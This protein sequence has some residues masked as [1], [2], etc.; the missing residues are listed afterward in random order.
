MLMYKTIPKATCGKVHM[1]C[2]MGR[3]IKSARIPEVMDEQIRQRL[4][5]VMDVWILDLCGN[6]VHLEKDRVSDSKGQAHSRAGT[7][8][9]DRAVMNFLMTYSCK[10]SF[11]TTAK[12]SSYVN[13]A[14]I[15]LKYT[16]QL[17]AAST[18][19]IAQIGT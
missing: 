12:K 11:P 9:I 16:P 18:V 13:P 6:A 2:R 10:S 7:A 17:M 14:W 19:S 1:S 15:V 4:S 8:K 3:H 5:V